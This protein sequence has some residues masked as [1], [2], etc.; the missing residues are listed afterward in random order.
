[1][2]Q[3]QLWEVRA[4][5]IKDFI[6]KYAWCPKNKTYT[7]FIKINDKNNRDEEYYKLLTN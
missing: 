4:I 1:M 3:S 7:A 2:E 5:E 6:T